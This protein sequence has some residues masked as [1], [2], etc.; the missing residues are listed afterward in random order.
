VGGHQEGDTTLK[1]KILT[2]SYLKLSIHPK[3]FT[4]RQRRDLTIMRKNV[5][6]KKA[7]SFRTLPLFADAG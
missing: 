2:L 4:L 1:K 7:A 3:R 5:D 6:T